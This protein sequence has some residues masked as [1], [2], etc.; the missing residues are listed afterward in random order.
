[1][2][3]I[4]IYH[5]DANRLRLITRPGPTSLMDF[6]QNSFVTGV[7]HKRGS[8]IVNQQIFERDALGNKIRITSSRGVAN[9]TYDSRE[10][11]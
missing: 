8:Q 1:M 5:D 4:I 3:G 2:T 9:F 11:T 10:F 7:T 6:D